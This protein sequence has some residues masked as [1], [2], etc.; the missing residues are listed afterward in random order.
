MQI[1][2][3]CAACL[4]VPTAFG[5]STFTGETAYS[6]AVGAEPSCGLSVQLDLAAKPDRPLAAWLAD[7]RA[8]GADSV[9]LVACELFLEGERR[10]TYLKDLQKAIAFFEAAGYPVIVW[11]STLGYGDEGSADRIAFTTRRG[12]TR[13]TGFDGRKTCGALCAADPKTV[14]CLQEN[15]RDFARIGAKTVLLDDEMVQ[16]RREN[17]SCLCLRHLS[18]ISSKAGRPVTGE[19]VKASLTGA[20]NAVRTAYFDAMGETLEAFVRALRAAADEVN[21]DLRIGLCGSFNSY[22]TEGS[23]EGRLLRILAGRGRP[24]L[25]LSGATYWVKCP[26]GS[27]YDGQEMG[28]VAEFFRLQLSWFDRDEVTVMDE[29][30][31]YPRDSKEID[32]R[33]VE[34]Y[35]TLSIV[36]GVPVRDKY[37]LRASPKYDPA[38]L[39]SHCA[40]EAEHRRLKALFADCRAVGWRVFKPQHYVRDAYLAPVFPDARRFLFEMTHPRAGIFLTLAGETTA[41]EE[42]EGSVAVF[43]DEAAVLPPARRR[44][45]LTDEAGLA[46]LR[47]TGSP[48]G[49]LQRRCGA[50]R[51]FCDD[52]GAKTAVV[53]WT[54]DYSRRPDH[55][56]FAQSAFRENL[57]E[58]HAFLSGK[59][60]EVAVFGAHEVYAYA[61]RSREGRLRVLL[62]NVTDRP[63]GPFEVRLGD[64][65]QRVE[66]IPAWGWRTLEREACVSVDF[67]RAAGRLRTSFS[68]GRFEGE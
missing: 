54:E 23:D 56:L 29:N 61:A 2:L 36:A 35:D 67:G 46:A 66:P 51:L 65:V 33:M 48:V 55:P 37:I 50:F 5:G 30:D 41:Y 12:L 32:T 18:L 15:I 53:D 3:L 11:T 16:A 6:A 26:W 45:V 62:A 60:P 14:A 49:N 59:K 34:L 58:V 64:R 8:S 17:M 24:L 1:L 19:D 31:S 25:R 43:G 68:L 47:R 9:Q 7:V 44:A 13:L 21:P 20:P 27:H 22:D 28:G 52:R 57:A 42:G 40:H 39:K 10:A 63:T 38:Y 4:A